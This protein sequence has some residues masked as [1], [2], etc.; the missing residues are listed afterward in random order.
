MKKPDDLFFHMY[1]DPFNQGGPSMKD[2]LLLRMDVLY[3]ARSVH[4]RAFILYERMRRMM[5]VAWLVK[6][7]LTD[8]DDRGIPFQSREY[9]LHSDQRW[10]TKMM[11][12][13]FWNIKV[14]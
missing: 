12:R 11:R 13:R 5:L 14:A 3:E 6:R 2:W 7:R 1:E 9:H 4:A 8:G 10:R